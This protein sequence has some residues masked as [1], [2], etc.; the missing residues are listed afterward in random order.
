MKCWT[1]RVPFDIKAGFVEADADKGKPFS[2]KERRFYEAKH[3]LVESAQRAVRL[4]VLRKLWRSTW[5]KRFV[6]KFKL[7]HEIDRLVTDQDPDTPDDLPALQ[8]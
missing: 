4:A 8:G 3:A 1:Q 5:R 7:E 6:A 2:A